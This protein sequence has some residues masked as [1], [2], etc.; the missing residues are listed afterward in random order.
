MRFRMG[1]RKRHKRFQNGVAVYAQFTDRARKT[2]QLVNQEAQ[3]FNHEYI[4]TEHILLGLV[5]V[6]IGV[7]ANILKNPDIDLQKVRRQVGSI[8][9][10]GPHPVAKT[11]VPLT[12]RAK[13]VPARKTVVEFDR[14]LDVIE[15]EKEE[16]VAAHDFEKAGSLRDLEYKLKKQRAKFIR[17]LSKNG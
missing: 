11:P 3:G 10:P 17:R 8:I 13:T 2:M 12:P 4:G 16:A 5:G 9:Q 15:Q 14:Q 6:G 1:L 7:G